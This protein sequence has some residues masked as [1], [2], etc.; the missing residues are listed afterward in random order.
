MDQYI[1]EQTGANLV[2]VP[3][4]VGQMSRDIEVDTTGMTEWEDMGA[5]AKALGAEFAKLVLAADFENELD[6]VLN[7][8]HKEIFITPEN[9]ILV[10]ACEVRLV[11]NMV[12]LDENGDALMP[13]EMG[14]LEFG[15]EFAFAIM[16][17][18][19][20]PE[21]FWDD[22]ITNGTTWD[23]TEWPYDS[24]AEA[25]DGV[26]IYPISITNDALGYVLTDNNFAFM[27]H[28]IGEEIADEVLSV[29]KH[30]GSFLVE[31]YYEMIEDF[32]K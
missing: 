16:P 28:I 10:L 9:S 8:T 32:V 24:L 7:V 27:G 29:G 31:E 6:P 13:S 5:S 25:V 1:K 12:F 30:M 21:T 2:M 20:Y 26:T 14:Y 15:N 23:G 22:E 4:A 11:N 18:E 17:A 3:G 19:F